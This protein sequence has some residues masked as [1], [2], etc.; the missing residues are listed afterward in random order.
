MKS[1]KA[2]PFSPTVR[3]AMPIAIHTMIMGTIGGGKGGNYIAGEEF[4]YGSGD[5]YFG[6]IRFSADKAF[7]CRIKIPQR[8]RNNK[9][10]RE[11]YD[12]C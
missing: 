11:R 1:L 2:L 3:R 10:N 12:G 8:K 7:Y 9:A 6:D 5:I 4:N